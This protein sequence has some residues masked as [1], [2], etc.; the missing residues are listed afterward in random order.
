[1]FPSRISYFLDL[2]GPSMVVDT[3]CS[4]LLLRYIWHAGNKKRR[5]VMALAG[6][7]KL[8]LV[9]AINKIKLDLIPPTIVQRLLTI[10]LTVLV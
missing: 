10:V 7:I 6:G 5:C 2:K 3:A 9:P 1:M 8:F 4:L